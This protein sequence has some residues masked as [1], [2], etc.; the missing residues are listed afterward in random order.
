MVNLNR[1][2]LINHI[3][4]PEEKIS[5]RKVIDKMESVMNSHISTSTDF[6]NPHEINLSISI[7]NRFKDNISYQVDG[8]YEDS[9]SSIIY[10]YPSYMYENEDDDLV[11]FKFDTN[12]KIKHWDILGS[13]LGL[14]I[15]RGKIG[16][17]LI[18]EKYTYFFVKREIAN[19][20]EINLTKVSR[21]NI[22]LS[23]ED[24]IS[25]LPKKEYDYKKII[26]SSFRLDNLIAKVFNLSRSKVKEMI[27]SELV[28][29]NFEKETRSHLELELGD[30]VSLRHYGRFRI[31]NIEGNTKKGNFV[32][33]VR[34]NKW[35][36]IYVC[37]YF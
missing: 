30:L 17:I 16:D 4:R 27:K 7:L 20:V 25:G 15:D 5:I 32:L 28:K 23:R 18:G 29:V 33:I 10:I 6:L 2:D 3:N 19:F 31:F 1:I 13:I 14:S 11:L 37:C 24:D 34:L 12:N 26:V 22:L 9:E 36:D 8:G 35:G 21:Y